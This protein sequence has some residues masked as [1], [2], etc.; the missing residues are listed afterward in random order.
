MRHQ[1]TPRRIP[2][3]VD[4]LVLWQPSGTAVSDGDWTELLAWVDKGN[5]LILSA[6][7]GDWTD[8]LPG[9]PADVGD[10]HA[11]SAAAHPATVGVGQV[12]T[13][14]A[15]FTRMDKPVLVHLT[16]PGG[17]PVLVSWPHGSGRIY[18]S[19]DPEWLTNDL[20]DQADNLTLA[21]GLLTPAPGKVVAFDEYHHGYEAI[22]RWYQI[23]RG[24]LRF[25]LLQ[26]VIALALFFWASGARFGAPV[27]LPPTPPRAAVEY[28]Y[29][30]SHLYARARSRAIVLQT[31]YRDLTHDLGR[32]LG[33]VRGRSHADIAELVAQ[34]TGMAPAAIQATLDGL[35]PDR[36]PAPAE[37][38]LLTLAR[39][40]D[41]IQRRVRNAGFRDQ[42]NP[43]PNRS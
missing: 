40:A 5:N 34:R 18:W 11:V 33:G 1:V 37:A 14:G 30:M 22:E 43:G 26:F 20:I 21:L 8:R 27:A 17:R 12:R 2:D 35:S 36:T 42:R 39:Q 7:D 24:P 13:G 9:A 38:E 23:L 29:S 16:D 19:A 15:V 28:V 4:R 41:D 31:L 6:T 3:S 32:L 10:L 25:L